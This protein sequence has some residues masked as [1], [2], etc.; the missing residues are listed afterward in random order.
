MKHFVFNLLAAIA[1]SAAS[2]I[3]AAAEL[4]FFDDF[5]YAANSSTIRTESDNPFVSIGGWHYV[6]SLESQA[7]ASRLGSKG[8]LTTV[9]KAQFEAN[10]GNLD[11]WPGSGS[12]NTLRMAALNVEGGTDF[13][14]QLG[15]LDGR[16]NIPSNVY[17]QFWIYLNRHGSEITAVQN[18]HKFLYPSNDP[19]GSSTNKW[20]FSLSSSPYMTLCPDGGSCSPGGD[21]SDGRAYMIERDPSVGTKRLT[22][23]GSDNWWKTGP[24]L[25]PHDEAYIPSNEWRL[26]RIHFDTSN[27][28]AGIFEVWMRAY[29]GTWVKTH[30]WIGGETP[31]FEWFGFGAGGHQVLR[32]PST[33]G[34]SDR[35]DGAYYYLRDFAMAN[36]PDSLPVYEDER[37]AP[38]PPRDVGVE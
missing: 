21:P 35:D 33:I 9:S 29:G 5:D 32:M 22:T 16:E 14:L 24:N 3:P 20:L 11:P 13:Y 12:G 25:V 28:S 4:L 27:N 17:F 36:S 1:F 23:A 15:D 8:S 7:Y 26:V 31:N 10:T 34:W 38:M 30:E 37:S 19:Y 18:R 6:K 2:S